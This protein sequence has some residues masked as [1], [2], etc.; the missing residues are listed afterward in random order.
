MKPKFGKG[1]CI[2]LF[3]AFALCSGR[4]FAQIHPRW[5]YQAGWQFNI[6]VATDVASESS[7]RGFYFDGGYY[8]SRTVSI[9][10]FLDYHTNSERI[11]RSVYTSGTVTVSTDQLQS[12]LQL[13]FGLSLRYRFAERT[14]QPYVSAKLGANYSEAASVLRVGRL[15]DKSWGFYTS[16]EIGINIFPFREKWFGFNI[17]AYYSYATNRSSV[18]GARIRGL[19][20]VGLR[21]GITF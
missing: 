7:G 9:G 2:L 20:N 5:Y 6:P 3:A 13:P 11:A 4:A 15:E 12:V 16:P 1:L 8:L 18:L 14:W 17:A 21:I 19:N 10:G